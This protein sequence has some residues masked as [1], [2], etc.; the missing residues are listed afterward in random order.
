MNGVARVERRRSSGSSRAILF[1][2]LGGELCECQW[3]LLSE[4]WYQITF[5]RVLILVPFPSLTLLL[6]PLCVVRLGSLVEKFQLSK[7]KWTGKYLCWQKKKWK[8]FQREA[9]L[10]PV[11][12]ERENSTMKSTSCRWQELLVA[13]IN[14]IATITFISHR[15][16]D[17]I[18]L[19]I[20]NFACSYNLN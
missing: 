13:S 16:R 19:I 1:G 8:S 7:R 20:F 12:T 15:E 3:I 6:L 2:L 14:F 5:D 17:H 10:N 18:N 11:L 4:M 9:T